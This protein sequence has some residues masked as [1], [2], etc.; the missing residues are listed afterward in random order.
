[1][2]DT[3]D[4][5]FLNFLSD[6]FNLLDTI[7]SGDIKTQNY[8]VLE[9][10]LEKNK[11]DTYN[12]ND[13]FIVLHFENDYYINEEYGVFVNNFIRLWKH[14]SI[15]FYTLIFYTN[16]IGISKEIFRA[17]KYH[18]PEDMPVVF[19]TIVNRINHPHKGYIRHD[20]SI[21]SIDHHLLYLNAGRTEMDAKFRPHRLAMYNE[22]KHLY[23]EQLV[24]S[25]FKTK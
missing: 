6:E 4:R 11:K 19:E 15:P 8:T 2:V 5:S 16:H 1:M 13:R 25:A 12:A 20:I 23:P 24:C 21:E 3:K 22:I 7:E 10:W 9:N 18:D 17:L 14:Y